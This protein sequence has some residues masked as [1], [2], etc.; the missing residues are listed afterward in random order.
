MGSCTE[1]GSGV[2]DVFAAHMGAGVD[3]PRGVS[4]YSLLVSCHL[5]RE[6]LDGFGVFLAAGRDSGE[7]G[8]PYLS[9][10]RRRLSEAETRLAIGSLFSFKIV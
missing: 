10:V 8:G 7:H 6:P 5:Q 1:H 2:G 3:F 9:R 4:C